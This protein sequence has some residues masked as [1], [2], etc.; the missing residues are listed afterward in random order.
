M[1][2]SFGRR[3]RGH[4]LPH[5]RPF[6]SAK[7]AAQ[8]GIVTRAPIRVL[9]IGTGFGGSVHAP[10]FARNPAFRLVG[11]ASGS[12]ENARRVADTF[13]VSY[14][15]DDWGRMLEEVDADLVSIATPVDQHGAMARAAID[16]G[17]HVLCE[18]PFA[19]NA[20]EAR[21]LADQARAK[22]IVHVVNHE[23]RHYPARAALTR[24]IQ[25]GK[26]GHIEHIVIRERISGWARSP[27]RKLTWLTQK[28]RGGGYL[29]ALGSHHV[30]QLLLWGGPIRRVLCSLRTLA[31]EPHEASPEHRGITADDGF[32]L[33]AE[34]A[35]GARAVVDLFGGAHARGLTMEAHGS[36]DALVLTDPYRLVRPLPDR[37]F[38]EV[39]IPADLRIEPTPE[40]PLLAPFSVKVEMIRAAI[41]EGKPASPD[42]SAGLE[43]QQVLDAARR[44]DES[45]GWETVPG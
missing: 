15:T 44:S 39:E 23:F 34:F 45:G 19:M 32:A 5:R 7:S 17:R 29:G 6:A 12:A 31:A 18:K 16:R 41:Q 35:G 30:D 40:Q 26:L 36:A 8:G 1:D 37:T 20:A 10:G 21:A 33:L 9:L 11:V 25:E 13:Q 27:S 22:G 4:L 43:I 28:N 24:R 14:A 2:G 3:P 42:F 38:E